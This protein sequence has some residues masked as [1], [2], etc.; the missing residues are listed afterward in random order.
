MC[1]GSHHSVGSLLGQRGKIQENLD[2]AKSAAYV[3]SSGD[4][5]YA[6]SICVAGSLRTES[7]PALPTVSTVVEDAEAAIALVPNPIASTVLPSKVVKVAR[8]L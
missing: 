6:C 4:A 2:F 1:L 3:S 8:R 5:K 7:V